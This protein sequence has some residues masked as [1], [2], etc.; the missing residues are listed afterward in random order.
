MVK[1]RCILTI[2]IVSCLL[3]MLTGCASQSPR[4]VQDFDFD[5]KFMKADI[6]GAQQASYVDLGWRDVQ[7]PHDWSIE[8]PLQSGLCQW[9]RFSAGRRR[10]VSQI[11]YAA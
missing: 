4:V 8:G 7:L 11:V 10:L 3:L 2:G 5:W 1:H 6:P 9:D